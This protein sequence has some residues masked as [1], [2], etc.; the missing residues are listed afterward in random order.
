[1]HESNQVLSLQEQLQTTAAFNLLNN[2]KDLDCL[3]KNIDESEL[4]V[5]SV[6]GQIDNDDV[7]VIL[8]TKHIFFLSHGL[9]GN[10]HCDDVEIADLKNLNYST[11]LAFT[12]IE[13]CNGSTT[14]ILNAI[15]KEDGVQFITELNHAITNIENDRIIANKVNQTANAKFVQDE[16][17]RLTRLHDHRIINDIDFNN[18]K[19]NLLFTQS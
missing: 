15:K 19:A 3:T 10:P 4:I 12:K 17:D 1:M 14:T 18:E 7:T 13:F 8:T 6:Q 16:L 9:L 5:A 2:T 11:G